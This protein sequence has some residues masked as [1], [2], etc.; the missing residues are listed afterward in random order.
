MKYRDRLT[1]TMILLATLFM[2]S[3]AEDNAHA[4]QQCGLPEPAASDFASVIYWTGFALTHERESWNDV[5]EFYSEDNDNLTG[6]GVPWGGIMRGLD[7][8]ANGVDPGEW[9]DFGVDVRCNEI[10]WNGCNDE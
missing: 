7:R 8:L 2:L 1:L 4:Q 9:Q 3:T 5:I 10:Y 6:I